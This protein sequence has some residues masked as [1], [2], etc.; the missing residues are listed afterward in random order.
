[1][2]VW[3]CM[4]G[5]EGAGEEKL[6]FLCSCLERRKA[7]PVCVI[8]SKKLVLIHW[9]VNQENSS[10]TLWSGCVCVNWL[11]AVSALTDY[12]MSFSNS[13]NKPHRFWSASW[14]SS[15][16]A[17]RHPQPL[18]LRWSPDNHIPQW[19]LEVEECLTQHKAPG[20]Q[21]KDQGRKKAF[22]GRVGSGTVLLW[23]WYTVH[24]HF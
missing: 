18:P 5:G 23:Q 19:E 4:G 2:G 14:S 22:P 8:K 1:M 24:G 9:C 3:E 11:T 6:F 7:F 10:Y 15:C 17:R 12:S 16:F 21:D 20:L 13:E